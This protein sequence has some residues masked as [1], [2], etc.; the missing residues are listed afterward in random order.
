ML[1]RFLDREVIQLLQSIHFEHPGRVARTAQAIPRHGRFRLLV[2]DQPSYEFATT[3]FDCEVR[4]CPDTAF[5]LGTLDHQG[6]PEVD[7]F[8][9]MRTDKERALGAPTGPPG[10][11]SWVADWVTESRLSIQAHKLLGIARGLRGGWPGRA[12]LRRVRYDAAARARVVRGCR[13]L[14]SGRVVITDRLHAH[15]LCLRLGIPHAVLGNS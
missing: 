3:N 15:I 12:A 4:L 9:L 13:L 6:T 5:F 2:R 7:I 10:Y 14:S 11:T 8:Y 1:E